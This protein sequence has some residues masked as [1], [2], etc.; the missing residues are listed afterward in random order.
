MNADDPARPPQ[1][2][3]EESADLRDERLRDLGA[4]MVG[5]AH[6]LNTPLGVVISTCDGLRRCRERLRDLADRPTLDAEDLQRLRGIVDHMENGAP[7]L[8]A[9]LARLEA[10]VRELRLQGR[11]DDARAASEPVSIVEIL[12]GD[13]LL[14]SHQLKQ[15]VHVER[16]FAARPTVRGHAV[17]LGQAFLNL[18]RNAIQAM[19]GQGTLTLTV[20]EHDAQVEVRVSDTGPGI[21]EDVLGRLFRDEVTTKC[22]EEGTGIG[23]LS[24]GKIIARHG[25]TISAANAPGGGA[26][27]TVTLPVS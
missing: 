7:V 22:S 24:T 15:G 9:G 2:S 27:F 25:G 8:A 26:V 12:E 4:M 19:Q 5:I 17:F 21:P 6:E 10:L 23:L 16:R 20:L 13:L 11:A 14:L 18:M 3:T 1:G